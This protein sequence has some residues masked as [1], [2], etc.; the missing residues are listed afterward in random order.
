MHWQVLLQRLPVRSL[1]H[2]LLAVSRAVRAVLRGFRLLGHVRHTGVLGRLGCQQT[3]EPRGVSH[4]VHAE[5]LQLE[6]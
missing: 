4:A 3:R 2:R 5:R 1:I 6:Q